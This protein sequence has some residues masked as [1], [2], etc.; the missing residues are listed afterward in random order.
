MHSVMNA[1]EEVDKIILQSEFHGCNL[2][3]GGRILKIKVVSFH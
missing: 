3:Y 1:S 2:S